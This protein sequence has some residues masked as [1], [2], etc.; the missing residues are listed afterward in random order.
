LS[1]AAFLLETAYFVNRCN[2]KDWPDSIKTNMGMAR[3]Y[4]SGSNFK[5]AP[6]ATKRNRIYQ[7]AAANMFASWGEVLANKL[8]AI[9]DDNQF[10][11]EEVLSVKDYFNESKSLSLFTLIRIIHYKHRKLK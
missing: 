11:K 1:K 9:I 3:P 2:R 8:E 5:H 7:L 4:G 6:N 10:N